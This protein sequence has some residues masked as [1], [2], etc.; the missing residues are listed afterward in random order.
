MAVDTLPWFQLNKHWKDYS[1]NQGLNV[2]FKIA[3]STYNISICI[4][5]FYRN[6]NF[7]NISKFDAFE[8]LQ[9]REIRYVLVYSVYSGL[10][11]KEKLHISKNNKNVL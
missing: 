2:D 8:F 4:F 7:S 9:N 10:Y 3:M 11:N 1:L 5:K 6:P